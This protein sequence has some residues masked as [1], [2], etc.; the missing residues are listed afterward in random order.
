LPEYRSGV[1]ISPPDMQI[2]LTVPPLRYI[3]QGNCRRSRRCF[4]NTIIFCPGQLRAI[5]LLT[6]L[7]HSLIMTKVLSNKGK[8][9]GNNG[10]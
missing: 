8:N 3:P 7:Q 1:P 6:S 5:K 4:K 10:D 9:H 2:R